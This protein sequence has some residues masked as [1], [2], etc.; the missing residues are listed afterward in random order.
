MEINDVV[1][2]QRKLIEKEMEDYVYP[3]GK[4]GVYAKYFI[5]QSRY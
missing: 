2:L 4:Y 3:D 1:E 5:Y